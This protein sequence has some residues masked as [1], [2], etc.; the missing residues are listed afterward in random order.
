MQQLRDILTRARARARQLGRPVL[1]SYSE[2]VMPMDPLDA[3]G[4]D[5]PQMYWASA[6]RGLMLAGLG[7]AAVVRPAGPQR[8]HDA[9]RAAAQLFTDAIVEPAAM[10]PVLMGGFAFDHQGARTAAW[11][12][13]DTSS[14][15]V[16]QVLLRR[17]GED[18]GV[19]VCAL[20]SFETDVETTAAELE[21]LQ[22]R[23][24]TR[25]AGDAAPLSIQTTVT[26][27]AATP[28]W[29]EL[30]GRA[31]A[32]IR[33]GAMEKVVLAREECAPIPEVNVAATLR[34]L[35]DANRGAHIY[36]VWRRGGVFLGAS[37][38]LLVR[39]TGRE[40]VTSVLAGSTRRGATAAEDSSLGQALTASVKDREEHAIVRRELES[41]LDAVCEHIQVNARPDLMMLPHVQHLHT[42]VRARLRDGR[43]AC[44]VLE[45]L[46]P[47]PAVGGAPREAALAFIRAHEGIDRGW[48]AAPVGW[49]DG[50][51][52]EFAVALRCALIRDGAAHLFAGCG[53]VAGSDPDAEWEESQLKLRPAL[54]ALSVGVIEAQEAATGGSS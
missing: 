29:T 35:R 54:E 50:V 6:D 17:R 34:H 47:T 27:T 3:L 13:F 30:I 9:G 45:R 20:V 10:N 32:A 24:M 36:A 46:H 51:N 7:E 22:S 15:V 44:D 5:G 23:A 42:A 53:I 1:A 19:T 48:Y 41:A 49:T 31:V 37:P 16:P 14:L 21:A 40:V 38:E 26:A 39:L 8:F 33:A 12:G 18:C 52:A 11:S 28:E 2:P 25:R 4:D 43:S